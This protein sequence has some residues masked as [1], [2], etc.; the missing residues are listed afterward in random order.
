MLKISCIHPINEILVNL[1]SN[2]AQIIKDSIGTTVDLTVI[3]P[4]PTHIHPE[5]GIPQLNFDQF[6]HVASIVNKLS[7]NA[8]SHATL[9]KQED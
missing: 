9:M 6:I 3:P 5:T 4:T 7:K 8:L 2:I 1:T